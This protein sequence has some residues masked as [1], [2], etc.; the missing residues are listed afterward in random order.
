M[1]ATTKLASIPAALRDLQHGK[2]VVVVD[3]AKRENEGDVQL[4]AATATARW[5]NFM[6][7]HARGLVCL[8]LPPDRL[9]QL[10]LQPMVEKNSDPFQ[11]D[12]AV[13]VNARHG[14]TT[15]VSAFDR[16]KTIQTLID[17]NTRPQDLVRPGHVFPLRAK[18]GGVLQR[19]G[20]TEAAVD[21]ATL[22]GFVPAGVTCEILQA[23]GRMARLPQL[24]QFAKRHKLKLI[25]IA[26]LIAYR[27]KTD[28]TVR[29]LATAT[30]PN[31]YG[32]WQV[33]AFDQHVALVKGDVA[34]KKN[35]LVRVHSE[36]FTGDV[37]GS[38]RC[39]CGEQLDTAMQMINQRGS[40]VVVYLRQEGRGIGLVNKL[41]AYLLQDS[42]LDTVEANQR[43]GF[44]ADLREYGTGA[45]I[46]RELGLSTIQLLTNNPKKIIGLEG[47]GLKVTKQLSLKM[48][49][50]PHNARYLHTKKTKLGHW[51]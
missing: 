2:P 33:I 15:G 36:C 7:T 28:R 49:P 50:N 51:L 29:A 41:H 25:S 9:Q 13:S 30:I 5:I 38:L 27:L 32:P 31:R 20:H 16:A 46:L 37:L 1:S 47:F 21:L 6:V 44:A 43:L 4:P 3:D 26:D 12:F 14:V 24:T 23:D 11:T 42:G 18:A 40:G 34:G 8:A 17:T 22:A 35:V 45:Q 39:D 10:Q 19:A 48:T